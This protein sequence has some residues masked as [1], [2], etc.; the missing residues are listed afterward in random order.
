[1]SRFDLGTASG[2]P[3]EAGAPGIQRRQVSSTSAAAT[4][5]VAKWL[6]PAPVATVARHA[7]GSV[8]ALNARAGVSRGAA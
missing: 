2:A 8:A 7:T 3:L 5:V 6:L 4:T 1:M